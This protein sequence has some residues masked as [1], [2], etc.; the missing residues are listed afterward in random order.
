MT[1]LE[2]KQY[3]DENN[4]SVNAQDC[5]MKVFNTSYQIISTKYNFKNGMMTIITPDNKFIFEWV[6][7]KPE[8]E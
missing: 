4:W 2:I 7:G 1:D 5:L 3:L 6:L 8:E